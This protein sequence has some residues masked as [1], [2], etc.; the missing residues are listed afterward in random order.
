MSITDHFAPSRHAAPKPPNLLPWPPPPNNL[1][2]SQRYQQLDSASV[3]GTI[4][5]KGDGASDRVLSGFGLQEA[6]QGQLVTGGGGIPLR[7]TSSALDFPKDLASGGSLPPPSVGLSFASAERASPRSKSWKIKAPPPSRSEKRHHTVITYDQGI[8]N[9]ALVRDI[10]GVKGP[11]II[12]ASSQVIPEAV[13]YLFA[14]QLLALGGPSQPPGQ[15]SGLSTF[16][17]LGWS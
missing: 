13:G 4:T 9:S 3:P 14:D 7:F 8:R 12:Q 1:P 15:G 6:D 2:C 16:D 5:N 10:A 11:D 17:P